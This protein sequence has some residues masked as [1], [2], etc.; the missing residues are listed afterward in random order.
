MKLKIENLLFYPMC[1]TFLNIQK[2]SIVVIIAFQKLISYNYMTGKI[3]VFIW[4]SKY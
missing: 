1:V 3:Y 4:K 2:N